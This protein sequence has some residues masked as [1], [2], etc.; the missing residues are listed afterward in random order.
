MAPSSDRGK[1]MITN[2]APL[3]SQDLQGVLRRWSTFVRQVGQL[4]ASFLQ[5]L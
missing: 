2:R 1:I 5:S 4:F 3:Y